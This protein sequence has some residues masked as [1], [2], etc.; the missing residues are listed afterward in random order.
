MNA[1][2]MQRSIDLVASRFASGDSSVRSRSRITMRSSTFFWPGVMPSRSRAASPRS[3]YAVAD[4]T[5]IAS[6]LELRGPAT[7]RT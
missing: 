4:N 6:M 2:L 3:P 7:S 5:T 1:T